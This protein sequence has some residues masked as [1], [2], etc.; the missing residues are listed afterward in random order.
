M[1]VASAVVLEIWALVLMHH[2]S[3]KLKIE[4]SKFAYDTQLNVTCNHRYA[5]TLAMQG[6][7]T[8]RAGT[9]TERRALV[10]KMLKPVQDAYVAFIT[11]VHTYELDCWLN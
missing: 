6:I 8:T 10:R 5:A 4:Q 11:C 1:P 7:P 9:P 2:W 3:C